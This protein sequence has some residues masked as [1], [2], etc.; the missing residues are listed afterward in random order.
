V[1]IVTANIAPI[2]TTKI[3]PV[4]VRPNQRMASGTQAMD[5]IDCSPRTKEPIVWLT[6]STHAIKIPSTKP[7]AIAIVRPI[8]SL[9]KLVPI[10]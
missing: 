3:I 1:L 5:G 7:P 8:P 2:A 6:V 10:P 4:S 9:N